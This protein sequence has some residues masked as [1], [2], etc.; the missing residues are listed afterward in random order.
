MES[1][2]SSSTHSELDSKEHENELEQ[3]N[4]GG[5]IEN[6]K[7]QSSSGEG[8]AAGRDEQPLL[9]SSNQYFEDSIPAQTPPA[10]TL[11][12]ALLRLLFTTGFTIPATQSVLPEMPEE[13][14]D[15]F[16]WYLQYTSITSDCFP[17]LC[18]LSKLYSEVVSTHVS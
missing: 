11:V 13:L 16:I 17:C 4:S 15:S 8:S 9:M 5:D 3:T 6:S 10:I 2:A 1:K 12:N 14:P 18:H 7:D